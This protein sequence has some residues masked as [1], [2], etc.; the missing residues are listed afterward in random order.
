MVLVSVV[1]AVLLFF[2]GW[3]W[4]S[5]RRARRQ[6]EEAGRFVPYASFFMRGWCPVCDA[7][8]NYVNVPELG[9]FA[10]MCAS[11]LVCGLDETG[12]VWEVG[13]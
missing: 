13:S 6:A 3:S 9:T 2:A 11:C 5:C 4:W 1:V 12:H 8:C 7:R 10:D